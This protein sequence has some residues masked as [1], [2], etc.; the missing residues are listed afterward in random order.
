MKQDI[1]LTDTNDLKVVGGDFQIAESDNQH[2]S[3]LAATSAGQWKQY[4]A[5][6]MG[7]VRFVLGESND[8]T[9]MLHIVDVQLKADG[10][11][12]KTVKFVNNQLQIDA[13][14]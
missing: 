4:P 1:Q 14:Y 3:L 13:S 9:K 12:S 11:V 10:V 6:G 2:V 7:L 8:V 5:A